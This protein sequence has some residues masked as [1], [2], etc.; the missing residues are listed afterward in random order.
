MIV[1]CKFCVTR[2]ENRRACL[3]FNLLLKEGNLLFNLLAYLALM[4]S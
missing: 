4:V 1:K 2:N 3:L